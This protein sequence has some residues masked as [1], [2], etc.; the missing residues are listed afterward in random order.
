MHRFTSYTL[1]ALFTPALFSSLY[2]T[3]ARAQANPPVPISQSTVRQL[4]IKGAPTSESKFVQ[5]GALKLNYITYADITRSDGAAIV[6]LPGL[7]DTAHIYD[8]LAPKLVSMYPVYALSRRG[9][10][11]SDKSALGDYSTDSRV[12]DLAGFLDALKIKK[13][14]LIGHSLAGDELTAFAAKYPGAGRG[15]GLLG[16]RL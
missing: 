13:V 14:I 8:D 6:L 16:S 7:T 3:V 9:C 15:S 12:A 10:G 2:A 1:T 5:V 4:I 11:D